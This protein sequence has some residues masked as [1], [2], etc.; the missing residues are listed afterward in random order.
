MMYKTKK[1]CRD[2][3]LFIDSKANKLQYHLLARCLMDKNVWMRI[4][5]LKKNYLINEEK[6]FNVVIRKLHLFYTMQKL[7]SLRADWPSLCASFLIWIIMVGE[8]KGIVI[9]LVIVPYTAFCGYW[10]EKYKINTSFVSP[11]RPISN[12]ANRTGINFSIFTLIFVENS[13]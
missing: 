6:C 13:L 5:F 3:K 12:K 2:R 11:E 10:N 4:Y 1:K 8:D 7:I 9:Y